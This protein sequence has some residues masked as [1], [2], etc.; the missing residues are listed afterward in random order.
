M[1]KTVHVTIYV[2]HRV[3]FAAVVFICMSGF[4]RLA[5]QIITL[6][7]SASLIFL[8][9]PVRNVP[10]YIIKKI[11][12]FC[13]IYTLHDCNA[14]TQIFFYCIKHFDALKNIINIYFLHAPAGG[15]IKRFITLYLY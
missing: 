12:I 11:K 4:L 3:A 14:C 8:E 1:H 7:A 13:K 15:L 2:S 6:R 10:D 9:G 5:V